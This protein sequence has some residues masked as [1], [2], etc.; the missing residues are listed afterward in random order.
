MLSQRQ[1][2]PGLG[3]TAAKPVELQAHHKRRNV[4]PRIPML[5]GLSLRLLVM[6][7]LFVIIAEI[8]IYWPSVAGYRLNWLND[9][10]AAARVAAL[11]LQ[12]APDE[13][14]SEE[15]EMDLLSGVGVQA[16]VVRGGQRSRLLSAGDM[17]AEV[18]RVIDLRHVRWTDLLSDA[19]DTLFR[20]SKLPI[21]LIGSAGDDAD[22]VEVIFSE[23]PL[24]RAMFD[25]SRNLMLL[26]A[27]ISAITAALLYFALQWLIVRPVRRLSGNITAFA[28]NPEDA[29][30]VIKPTG[31]SD[32]IGLAEA[33]LAQMETTL[34]DELRQKRRLA[35]LGLA[36]SKINHELRNMLTTAQLLTE[37]LDFVHDEKARAV[38]P[39]LL[40]TLGRAIDF[41]ESTLA[42]GRAT[43]HLPRRRMIPLAPLVEELAHLTDL[44]PEKGIAFQADI[45]A[46]LTIDADPE[47]LS[48]IL[49]NLIRNAVQ[50]LGRAND[51]SAPR[52]GIV[53]ITARRKDALVEM[54][55]E[56]NG[57]GIPP[58]IREKLFNAF[59][60]PANTGGAGLG[61]AI[62][63][64]LVH[65]HDGTISLEEATP[66]SRF[67]IA[68]PDRNLGR[69]G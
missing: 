58:R 51:A 26:T 33:A 63:A 48:R 27:V 64:E 4:L 2:I 41:C 11:V 15:M 9:R 46:D 39:R 38:A 53:R 35:D 1:Q 52:Y 19:V 47:Q 50:A 12:A 13:S 62:V 28:K 3:V 49:V 17:P 21:R 61:L 42:Y 54:T 31:R 32:E 68:I 16:I 67:R 40:A 20:P 60:S 69:K 55:V 66:G 10:L 5:P 7:I 37:R 43:E 14:L 25:F 18:G 6:T 45:P 57:P 44:A 36:V 24:R 23:R 59:Q 30:R 29:A 34:A 65:L 8:L 22:L 56:D